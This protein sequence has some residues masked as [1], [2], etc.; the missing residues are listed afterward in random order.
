MAVEA[1]FR[2]KTEIAKQN[3]QK[4][5]REGTGRALDSA[6]EG[7]R[8]RAVRS[9]R[10]SDQISKPGDPP[11]VHSRDPRRSLLNM[12]VSR[13]EGPPA[14]VF[15]GPI[16]ISLTRRSSGYRGRQSVPELLE[17]GGQVQVV[18]MQ[19]GRRE[20][21][22][23]VSDLRLRLMQ[24]SGR[25]RGVSRKLS[26]LEDTNLRSTVHRYQARPFMRPAL[27]R[28]A[29]SGAMLDRFKDCVRE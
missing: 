6:G 2:V 13:E 21:W 24:R 29:K 4:K 8:E 26:N 5:I 14:T 22:D 11:H 17:F 23:R 19:D 25:L 15:I 7:V 10:H 1:E 28:E 27:E 12:I 16:P 3:L 9:M 20:R 18:Q